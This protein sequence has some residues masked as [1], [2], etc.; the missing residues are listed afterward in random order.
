MSRGLIR[1]LFREC[2]P[3]VTRTDEGR[4]HVYTQYIRNGKVIAKTY[5]TAG[6]WT[7]LVNVMHPDVSTWLQ[8]CER[9][10]SFAYST[11]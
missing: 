6:K 11:G 3:S 4:S 10:F 2:S 1:E 8:L 9:E 7:F 5:H